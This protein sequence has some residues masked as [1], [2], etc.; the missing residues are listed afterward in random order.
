MAIRAPV[1]VELGWFLVANSA[2][3]TEQPGTLLERYRTS[4]TWFL[5]R[6]GYGSY[7]ADYEHVVGDWDAQVDLARIVGL[8]LRGWRKGLDAEA[9][10]TLGSGVSGGTI[11]P[12]GRRSRSRPPAA[13]SDGQLGAARSRRGNTISA[14]PMAIAPTTASNAKPPSATVPLRM[15]RAAR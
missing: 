5:G 7:S 3:L 12:S 10:A 4:L 15:S 2:S 6:M 11:S 13:A 9:G 1:A 14:I 8:L